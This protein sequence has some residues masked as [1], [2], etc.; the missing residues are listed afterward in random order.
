MTKF[1]ITF[2]FILF[3]FSMQKFMLTGLDLAR[4]RALKFDWRRAFIDM[5]N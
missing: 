1:S 5:L 4:Y 3:Y 2:Y